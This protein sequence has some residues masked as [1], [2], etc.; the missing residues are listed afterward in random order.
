MIKDEVENYVEFP[1]ASTQRQARLAAEQ[2]F[3]AK[4]LKNDYR[5]G[6][7]FVPHDA[8]V[9]DYRYIEQIRSATV[10]FFIEK[11]LAE[12][13]RI[14]AEALATRSTIANA[15]EKKS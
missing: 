5:A 8:H 15:S 6:H 3:A 2:V 7:S 10:G 1:S 9:V 4:F 12:L 14:A 13:V 11:A